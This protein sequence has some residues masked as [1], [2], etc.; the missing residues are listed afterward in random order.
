M[1]TVTLLPAPLNLDRLACNLACD[2]HPLAFIEE[3]CERAAILEY[4][5]GM[6]RENAEAAALAQHIPRRSVP[7]C[8]P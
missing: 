8:S 5:G 4:D 7:A 1:L 6:T 2:G 3:I